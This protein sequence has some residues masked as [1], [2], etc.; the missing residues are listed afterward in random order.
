MTVKRKGVATAGRGVQN[1]LKQEENT[2]SRHQ[3]WLELQTRKNRSGWRLKESRFER[4][5]FSCEN[6]DSKTKEIVIQYV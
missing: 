5:K 6:S 3:L 4:S 2:Y 1:L